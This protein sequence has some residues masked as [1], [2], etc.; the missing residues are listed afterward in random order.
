[1]GFLNGVTVIELS[2]HISASAC[3]KPWL[4]WGPSDQDRGSNGR[5]ILRGEWGRFLKT[6]LIRK[7]AGSF[8]I[9]T[10]G[11]KDITLDLHTK[12]GQKIFRALVEKADILVEDLGPGVMESLG[13]GYRELEKK[14]PRLVLPQSL[15]LAKRAP[16]STT[17]GKTL[18]WKQRAA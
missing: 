3:T 2:E 18:F 11:K 15:L 8:S 1:M 6:N 17:N 9:S 10:R 5:V 12:E 13:L 16:M 14:V 7:R 4:H